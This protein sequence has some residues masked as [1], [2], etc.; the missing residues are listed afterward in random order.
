MSQEQTS[1]VIEVAPEQETAREE[2]TQQKPKRQPR[3]HVVLWDDPNHSFEYVIVMLKELFGHPVT[4]GH[5]IAETVNSSGRAIVLTTTMEHA[6]LKRD[7]IRAYGSSSAQLT[8]QGSMYA[9]IEA[10]TRD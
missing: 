6:E 7:Q 3:Y 2:A 10:E 4:E 1:A 8:S 5:K 9:T